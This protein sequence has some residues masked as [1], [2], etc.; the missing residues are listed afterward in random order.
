MRAAG[1]CVGVALPVVAVLVV[2]EPVYGD[3]GWRLPLDGSPAVLRGFDP[4]DLPWGAGHRGIDLA[5]SAGEPVYAAG[6]GRVGYVGRIA[7]RG[8]VTVLHD[9]RRTTYLPVHATVRSGERVRAGTRI[10][11]V[12]PGIFHCPMRVCLHWGLLRGKTYLD[13]LSLLGGG[14]IRLLPFHSSR[15]AEN[16]R[17]AAGPHP[18]AV[19][20]ATGKPASEPPDPASSGAGPAAIKPFNVKPLGARPPLDAPPHE[21]PPLA[22]GPHDTPTPPLGTPP[23]GTSATGT[24][25]AGTAVFGTTA[26]ETT[27]ATTS[28]MA[29]AWAA[30][31][32]RI[33]HRTRPAFARLGASAAAL[34]TTL[35]GWPAALA[36]GAV[37]TDRRARLL[38]DAAKDA[39]R[40]RALRD[41]GATAPP[42]TAPQAHTSQA[43]T[44]Q[45]RTPV[46]S[47]LRAATLRAATP[48]AA[49]PEAAEPGA[50]APLPPEHRTAEHRT[51]VL[52]AAAPVPAGPGT[53]EPGTAEPGTAAAGAGAARLTVPSTSATARETAGGE[54]GRGAGQGRHRG[55][56]GPSLRPGRH[57]RPVAHFAES[58]LAGSGGAGLLLLV[59]ALAAR[60][61]WRRSPGAGGGPVRG[62][63]TAMTY[64]PAGGRS[65]PPDG[66][67]V[68]PPGAAN[69][70]RAEPPSTTPPRHQRPAARTERPVRSGAPRPGF[71]EHP[72]G[73]ESPAASGTSATAAGIEAPGTASN[74]EAAGATRGPDGTPTP[75]PDAETGDARASG[76]QPP[77]DGRHRHRTSLVA[78]VMSMLRA[79][80]PDAAGP[81]AGGDA[82]HYADVIDLATE[83]RLRRPTHPDDDSA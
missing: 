27:Q 10:G 60:I 67:P 37:P 25:S 69:P 34:A 70:P 68:S 39:P 56:G 15:H 44:S 77:P 24:G 73:P 4:P 51:A 36:R 46:K 72:S 19:P 48:E 75:P 6:A 40:R 13:P 26:L 50:A 83:R 49:E 2:A 12:E 62:R 32:M 3:E 81:P 58:A 28:G 33:L 78:R 8:I 43:D 47:A 57:E 21:I 22:A 29:A 80:N 82:T 55:S 7:G 35:P 65:A 42:A 45:A 71:D 9:T 61:P 74:T 59:V 64:H 38:A 5:A 17:A 20:S 18:P 41:P 11:T 23:L 76:A 66:S 54:A 30:G 52:G 63:E 14:P 79:L 16:G 53:A 1:L 31:G